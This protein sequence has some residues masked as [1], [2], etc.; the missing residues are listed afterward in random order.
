M[1]SYRNYITLIYHFNVS[2]TKIILC[3]PQPEL[4]ISTFLI[5]QLECKKKTI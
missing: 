4:Q 2:K 3:L 5:N 1:K